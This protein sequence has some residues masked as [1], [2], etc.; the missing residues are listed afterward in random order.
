VYDLGAV[1]EALGVGAGGVVPLAQPSAA[2]RG[3]SRNRLRSTGILIVEVFG[4]S[5]A[6][7]QRRL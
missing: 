7:A 6:G 2:A 3:S 1:V 5:G 4:P